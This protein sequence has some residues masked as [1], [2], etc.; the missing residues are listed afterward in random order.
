MGEQLSGQRI[1]DSLNILVVIQVP[2]KQLFCKH[3]YLL[4]CPVNR[5]EGKRVDPLGKPCEHFVHL[6]F[7]D[8]RLG[9][10]ESEVVGDV[11]HANW[12]ELDLTILLDRWAMWS[13]DAGVNGAKLTERPHDNAVAR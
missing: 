11:F 3:T 8:L 9:P 6:L 5:S 4:A 10:R 13:R 2:L 7:R 12:D 1:D